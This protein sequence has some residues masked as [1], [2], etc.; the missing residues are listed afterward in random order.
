[1]YPEGKA[2]YRTDIEARKVQALN[3][4]SPQVVS[5]HKAVEDLVGRLHVP[6]L[7]ALSDS[8]RDRYGVSIGR[9]G[10]RGRWSLWAYF[11]KQFPDPADFAAFIRE[12]SK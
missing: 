2:V 5:Y 12:V 11:K 6:K 10:R 3:V 1:M 9:V 8:V 4:K 7:Q